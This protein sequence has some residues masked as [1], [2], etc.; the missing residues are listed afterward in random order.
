MKANESAMAQSDGEGAATP[1]GQASRRIDS[2]S[3]LTR[4]EYDRVREKEAQG[5]GIRVSTLDT[6]VQKRRNARE[7][8]DA[9]GSGQTVLLADPEPWSDV[10]NGGDLLQELEGLFRAHL[11][12]SPGASETIALWVV[13]SHAH[14]AFQISPLLGITSP[15]KNCG[16]ST[17]LTLLSGVVPKP[18]PVSNITIAPLFRA[19]EKFRPTLLVD[20]ADTFISDDEGLRGILNSGWLRS[21]A[22]VI[23]TVGDDHEPRLFS[24]WAPKAIAMIGNLPGTLADR[25]V[26]VRMCRQTLEEESTKRKLRADRLG[27]LE[28]LRRKARRWVQDHIEE[29]RNAD[30]SVPEGF[31]NRLADNWRPL[32]AIA[33][34]VGGD[35]PQRA[36]DAAR[37]LVAAK[38]DESH[39]TL[40]LEDLRRLFSARRADR[41]SSADI[42][43]A[44]GDME[45]RPWPEYSHGRPITKRGLASILSRFK[46]GP[47][48]VRFSTDT[49]KGY[50]LEDL[51]E[52]FRRFLAQP[53]CESVTPSQEAPEAAPE[54][55]RNVTRGGNVTGGNLQESALNEHCDAVTFSKPDGA[56]PTTEVAEALEAQGGG[57]TTERGQVGSSLLPPQVGHAKLGNVRAFEE[58][59]EW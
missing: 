13:F 37:M 58:S 27:D 57:A 48:T 55:P 52:T 42:V 50:L 20:E 2:L 56:G 33:D 18:L 41:L 23:R 10:V 32:L 24:T 12:M 34:L 40:L 7:T 46:V 38:A 15:E 6:E 5:L 9:S 30:P 53:A 25:S 54:N 51:E 39:A 44:L 47:K 22:Q 28:H 8:P 1:Q 11:T 21:Q 29:L 19:V 17:L 26:A 59:S 49:V 35:W 36:R 3:T 31:T 4:V 43:A 16:K 14:D 45:D